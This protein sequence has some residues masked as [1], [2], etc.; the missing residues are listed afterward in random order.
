MQGVLGFAQIGKINADSASPEA[1]GEYFEKIEQSGK[2]LYQLIES[3]LKLAEAAWAEYSAVAEEKLVA[4]APRQ[5]VIECCTMMEATAR[6][7]QQRIVVENFSSISVIHGDAV[8]LR[9]VLEYLIGNALRYS[10]EHTQVIVRL[11]DEL[12]PA[13]AG[14]LVSKALSIQVIDEGCGIPEK[15][16]A[17]IFEPFYE[18]SRTA[19]GA[20]GTGLGLALSKTIV[21]RHK[22]TLKATNR[23]RCGAIFEVILPA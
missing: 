6:Q 14:P 12:A 13:Q 16:M 19:S 2:R 20:G 8:L 7:R 9:Q 3:L 5:L 21:E 10:P 15:E 22:R 11:Q 23:P 1:L 4:V 18:S 17:A